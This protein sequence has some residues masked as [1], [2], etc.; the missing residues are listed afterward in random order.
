MKIL[1]ITGI[2]STATPS[3]SSSSICNPPPHYQTNTIKMPAAHIYF[4]PLTLFITS[5]YQ[6]A[7]H[8]RRAL[9]V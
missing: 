2:T 1:I 5:S 9:C 8:A 4:R 7:Q 6:P 3:Y